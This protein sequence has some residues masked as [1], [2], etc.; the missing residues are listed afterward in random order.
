MKNDRDHIDVSATV[1]TLAALACWGTGPIFIKLLSF[2]V[3]SWTQNFLRYSV[4]CAFW[5]GLLIK[6]QSAG[7]LGDGIWKNALIP[8]AANLIMQ[9][10]WAMAFYYINPGFMILLSKSSIFWITLFSM[11]CFAAE[12]KLLKSKRFWTALFLTIIGVVGVVVNKADF[13]AKATIIGVVITLSTSFFWGVYTISVRLF[14]RNYDSRAAF[15]VVSLYTVIGLA[16]LAFIFGRP[17][18]ALS[19]GTSPWLYIII[20]GV[21]S[22][23]LSHTLYY[24]AINHIGATIP[25][26]VLLGQ[27]LIVLL[28]SKFI[29]AEKLNSAQIFFGAV[30]LAGAATAILSQKN[31]KNN[32]KNRR[33]LSEVNRG[34]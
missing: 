10:L 20:S 31:L 29:F 18:Q 24:A 28:I 7:K 13:A 30:L 25:S 8:T 34:Q 2:R 11:A 14:M 22:I 27:P 6:L 4:A 23:A 5:L 9:S 32:R 16:A 3:D 33:H 19:I 17:S 1:F 15:S 12:R 21:V 26:L